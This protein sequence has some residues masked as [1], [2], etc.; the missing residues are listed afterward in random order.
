MVEAL[1]RINLNNGAYNIH[2]TESFDPKLGNVQTLQG[3]K[4]RSPDQEVCERDIL[5]Q[6]LIELIEYSYQQG[7]YS[8]SEGCLERI[9]RLNVLGLEQF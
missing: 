3:D 4:T 5:A 6:S 9:S 1:V 7:A 2:F 8:F